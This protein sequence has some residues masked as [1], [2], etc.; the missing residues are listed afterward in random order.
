MAS[1]TPT[2]DDTKEGHNFL[3]VNI[4][5]LVV[6]ATIVS[7]RVWWRIDRNGSLHRADVCVVICLVRDLPSRFNLFDDNQLT[8]IQHYSSVRD[9]SR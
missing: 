8:A 1:V 2:V 7:F 4:P 3:Y 9:L 5:L 6:A